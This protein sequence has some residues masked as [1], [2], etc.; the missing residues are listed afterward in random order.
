MRVQKK[1]LYINVEKNLDWVKP[2]VTSQGSPTS[3]ES[4]EPRCSV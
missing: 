2:S 1:G 3:H 4:L